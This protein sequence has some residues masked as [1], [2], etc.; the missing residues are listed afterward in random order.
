MQGADRAHE[1][2]KP[3]IAAPKMNEFVQ[4]ERNAGGV[5]TGRTLRGPQNATLKQAARG[6][7]ERCGGE[8]KP[9][10][11]RDLRLAF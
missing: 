11:P 9:H 6:R 5:E 1:N 8:T 2:I 4:H 10:A 3:E 7:C